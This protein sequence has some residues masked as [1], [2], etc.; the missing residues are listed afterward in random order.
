MTSSPPTPPGPES[1]LALAFPSDP[2]VSPEGRRVAFVLSRVEEEQPRQPEADF[3]RPRYKSRLWLSDGGAARPLTQGEGRDSSPRWSPDGQTLAFVREEGGHKG[4]LFLLPL[5]GGEARRVTPPPGQHWRGAV[6][7]V[8]WSPDGRWVS[9]LSSGDD[10][11]NR[12]ERGEARVITR[13]RYRFNGRDW[14]PERPARLWRY[15][16]EKEALHEWLAPEVEIT[17][18][19]WWPDSRGILLVSSSSEEDAVQ[20]RQE[21]D[22]LLLS[23]ER[24]RVTRWNSAITAVI[25]HPDGQRFALVGRPEGKGSPEDN[26][27]FLVEPGGSW[28]RLDVHSGEGGWDRPVGNLVGG[29][30]HVGAFPERP[31]WLDAETLLFL[32]TVG[33]SCGLFRAALDGTVT[34]QDHDPRSVIAAFTARGGGLALLRERADRFPEV[35]LNGGQVTDLH[36]RLP[37]PARTPARVPF[38]NELGEGEGWVLLPDGTERAP[39]LLSIHGGPHTAYGHAFMHE[40]QL[41]AARGYGVCYGNPRGSVGYG[42]AWSSAIYGRWGTVD[43]ADLLAFFD[44][45]LAAQ[46]RLDGTRTAVMGGSYGGYMTNW[47]TGHTDRFQA[48]IT[49]RSICNLLSFGGTSDIGMRFWD[50]ELGL[51]FHRSA[52]ALKLWDMSPLKYVEQVRTPTLIVHS[53]LDHRCPIEQAEQWYAALRLHG[54]P[55]R[56]VRFPGEDH[57]LNR[58]GRPDRRL[59]RLGEYLGW[60]ERWLPGAEG[61]QP[62]AEEASA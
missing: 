12:D 43:M 53:V 31:V 45:C 9:F 27:L 29:D 8:Q 26:H 46:E 51:N 21:A 47:I 2:Q 7:D 17:G 32:S 6:Q 34:P 56:F 52:D 3:A 1:L 62:L 28:R 57:E 50:D 48:A 23:G 54:V 11:D 4:Q 22:T 19:A 44:A 24:T 30:C 55:V 15:D 25:P 58:S 16:V 42:Q 40:F 18:Y 20:W 41:F 59:T 38:T 14:L 36:D 33:G 35:E 60:L 5:T 49:D 61:R 39:A 37:F 13:S 10:E